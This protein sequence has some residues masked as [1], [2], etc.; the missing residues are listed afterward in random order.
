MLKFV[1]HLVPDHFRFVFVCVGPDVFGYLLSE[2]KP[3]EVEEVDGDVLG[4]HAE[5]LVP[6]QLNG[7][8]EPRLHVE[9]RL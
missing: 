5:V 4:E 2:R 3:Q 6:N 7:A 8:R 9:C 1:S